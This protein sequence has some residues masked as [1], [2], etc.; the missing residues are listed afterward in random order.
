MATA[1]IA[2]SVQQGP[3]FYRNNCVNRSIPVS[4]HQLDVG[5][6]CSFQSL[7]SLIYAPSSAVLPIDLKDL[8][9]KAQPSQGGRGVSLHQLDK[10]SL[11]ERKQETDKTLKGDSKEEEKEKTRDE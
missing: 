9:P 1:V 4:D 7:V 11:R 6:S 8:V 3:E 10:H 2:V 5:L